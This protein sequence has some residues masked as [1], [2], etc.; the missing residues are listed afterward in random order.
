[1]I[2]V[3]IKIKLRK[4]REIVG[5]RQR[6][7]GLLLALAKFVHCTYQKPI[8]RLEYRLWQLEL[9]RPSSAGQLEPSTS[10]LESHDLQVVAVQAS[11]CR[12]TEDPS[13]QI[14]HKGFVHAKSILWRLSVPEELHGDTKQQPERRSSPRHEGVIPHDLV[15]G[16]LPKSRILDWLCHR[17]KKGC[18]K[19]RHTVWAWGVT[20]LAM[21]LSCLLHFGL[22]TRCFGRCQL[23][24]H[25]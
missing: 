24:Q 2:N 11:I 9:R 18:D 16:V 3:L 20:L 19:L 23:V 8:N 22:R 17:A 10:Y 7:R 25:G 5:W 21:K 14:K 1:M 6:C 12:N 13:R 15:P 4:L